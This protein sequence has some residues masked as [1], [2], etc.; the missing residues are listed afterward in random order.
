MLTAQA[1]MGSIPAF[2]MVDDFLLLGFY[3]VGKEP[4]TIVG[5]FLHLYTVEE[6]IKVLAIPN[7]GSRV[8]KCIGKKAN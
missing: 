7:M 1:A 6:K 2:D 4:D 8:R 3:D 5:M